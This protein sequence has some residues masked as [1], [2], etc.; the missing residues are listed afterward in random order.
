MAGM[1]H[2]PPPLPPHLSPYGSSAVPPPV[3]ASVQ[4]ITYGMPSR[5]AGRPGI[6]TAIGLLSIILGS[7]GVLFHLGM[8]V[9]TFGVMMASRASRAFATMA[10]TPT[11]ARVVKPDD[12]NGITPRER[13]VIIEGL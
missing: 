1:S 12:D 13:R 7:F 5:S 10:V 8:G 4:P 9:T 3:P 11:P 2:V 6:I